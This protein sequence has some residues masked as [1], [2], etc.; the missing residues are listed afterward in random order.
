MEQNLTAVMRRLGYFGS[1][2]LMIISILTLGG[3]VRNQALDMASFFLGLGALGSLGFLLA[4][5]YKGLVFAGASAIMGALLLLRGYQQILSR[6]SFGN[7]KDPSDIYAV[8]VLAIIPAIILIVVGSKARNIT[9]PKTTGSVGPTKKCPN[10][11]EEVKLEAK[12]CR[13]C[14]YTFYD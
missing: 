2:W 10:C 7:R 12:I 3:D 14:R 8:T 11:A 6:Y 1:V 9:A 5:K 13:F 4:H